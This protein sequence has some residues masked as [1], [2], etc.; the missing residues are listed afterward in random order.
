GAVLVDDAGIPFMAGQ[1]ELADLAPRDV[2]AKAML[3]RMRETGTEHVWLDGRAFGVEKWR[4]RF[5]T[6]YATL[7]SLGIDPVHDQIPVI[8]ACHYASGGVR[9]DLVGRSS[10]PALYACGEAACTGVH[11][12]NRLAS[13]SLLEAIGF[14]RRIESE[15]VAY[16]GDP[17][18]S[19]ASANPEGD[20]AV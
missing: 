16:L 7:T 1:H 12:A 20:S 19:E 5:P 15:P 4:T 14:G 17:P 2:V 6:I 9:T 18:A 10:G 11:G 3:R 13:D 8:P